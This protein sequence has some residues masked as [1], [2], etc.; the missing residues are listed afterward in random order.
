MNDQVDAWVDLRIEHLYQAVTVVVLSKVIPLDPEVKI[1]SSSLALA[2]FSNELKPTQPFNNPDLDLP[3]SIA[4]QA[5]DTVADKVIDDLGLDFVGEREISTEG[6][7]PD[8]VKGS[9]RK[10][11]T[12]DDGRNG[13][14]QTAAAKQVLRSTGPVDRTCT[15]CTVSES[16]RPPGRPK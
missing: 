7:D 12:R 8:C 15:T 3:T 10:S 1:L 5:A 16:G 14:K 13:G 2:V 9:S 6:V 4:L 11:A